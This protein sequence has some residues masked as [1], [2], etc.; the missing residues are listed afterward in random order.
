MWKWIDSLDTLYNIDVPHIFSR[1]EEGASLRGLLS[2]TSTPPEFIVYML[3]WNIASKTLAPLPPPP[4][5]MWL[6]WNKIEMYRTHFDHHV[7]PTEPMKQVY[8]L[9]QGND[10]SDD[11]TL[12]P[13][14]QYRAILKRNSGRRIRSDTSF[15]FVRH[16][17]EHV[18]RCNI[19][20]ILALPCVCKT[21]VVCNPDLYLK[22]AI[23]GE[24]V[25]ASGAV[26]DGFTSPYLFLFVGPPDMKI[27]SLVEHMNMCITNHARTL[28]YGVSVIDRYQQHF[29]R[30]CVHADN[31]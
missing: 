26:A 21:R 5:C 9:L 7:S 2:S 4:T 8:C 17:N 20:H 12:L 23:G 31:P 30:Q 29:A 6:S 10:G 25:K 16:V 22:P 27:D 3:R 19:T 11:F 24:G 1:D 18:T 13:F 28:Q 15:Q 14:T